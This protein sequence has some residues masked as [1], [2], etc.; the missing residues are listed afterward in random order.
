[1]KAGH[2]EARFANRTDKEEV[3]RVIAYA[4]SGNGLTWSVGVPW[5]AEKLDQL[6]TQESWF[7]SKGCCA[8]LGGAPGKQQG[9]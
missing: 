3:H 8:G 7:Q 2:Y 4:L 6:R 9:Q 5:P 1:M